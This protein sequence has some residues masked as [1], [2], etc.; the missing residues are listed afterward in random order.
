MDQRITLIT[1]GVSDLAASRR[2]YI[3]GLGWKPAKGGNEHVTFIDCGGVILSL[4]GRDSLAADAH[5]D[6]KGSGFAGITIAHNVADR[7]TVDRVLREAEAAGAKILKKGQE[8][9]WGGYSGYFADPDG[10]LWEVA[11]N[12]F[13]PLDANG[14]PQLG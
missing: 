9:F 13:W 8:V 7:A 5:V 12:P 3:D 10:H 2:F 1:L 6:A 11:H 14:K 4:F